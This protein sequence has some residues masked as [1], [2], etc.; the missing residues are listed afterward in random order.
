[1]LTH[2]TPRRRLILISRQERSFTCHPIGF[3]IKLQ[4]SHSA[5]V[6]PST[7][8]QGNYPNDLVFLSDDNSLLYNR[9]HHVVIRWGTNVINQ[10]TGSFNID[11]VDRGYFV[12]PSGTVAPRTFGQAPTVLAIGNDYE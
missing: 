6:A 3:R 11:G 2:V 4:L 10:G 9:W 12:V 8:T 5:D 1:M 7:A